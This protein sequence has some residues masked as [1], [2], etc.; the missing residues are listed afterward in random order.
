VKFSRSNGHHAAQARGDGGLET[1]IVP[2][3]ITVPSLLSARLCWPPAAI[4]ITLF[5]PPG[6][7]VWPRGIISPTDDRSVGLER[8]IVIF[9]RRNRFNAA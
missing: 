2:H 9:S 7:V 1:D 3:P 4:A 6:V 8:Q 5:K